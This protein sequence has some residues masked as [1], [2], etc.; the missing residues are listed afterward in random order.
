MHHAPCFKSKETDKVRESHVK[1][2]LH[3]EGK[4]QVFAK[5]L[6][7][8]CSGFLCVALAVLELIL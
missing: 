7:L 5:Q 2:E 6:L 3:Q 8:A 1:S 4:N